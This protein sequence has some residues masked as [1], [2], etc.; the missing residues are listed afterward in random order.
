MKGT[1]YIISIWIFQL[2]DAR[3]E[4]ELPLRL[5]GKTIEFDNAGFFYSGVS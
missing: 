1:S 2:L 3:M 4:S 5:H